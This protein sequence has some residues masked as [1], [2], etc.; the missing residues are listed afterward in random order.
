MWQR[1]CRASSPPSRTSETLSC[2]GIV[3]SRMRKLLRRFLVGGVHFPS[4][5]HWRGVPCRDGTWR[6]LCRCTQAGTVWWSSSLGLALLLGLDRNWLVPCPPSRTRMPARPSHAQSSRFLSGPLS[7]CHLQKC[8]L[9]GLQG[10][11]WSRRCCGLHLFVGVPTSG[12]GTLRVFCTR[13]GETVWGHKRPSTAWIPS[14]DYLLTL[15]PSGSLHTRADKWGHTGKRSWHPSN[16]CRGEGRRQW[17]RRLW[18]PSALRQRQR[19][20]QNQ[21]QI[22]GGSLWPPI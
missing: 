3:L 19:F 15:F 22:F 5:E 20:D 13:A 9:R 18:R 10:Q 6:G 4:S 2:P 16:R 21:L 12:G 8:S 17:Q 14:F 7:W 1:R 11:R